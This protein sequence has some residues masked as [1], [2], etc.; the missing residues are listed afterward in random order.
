MNTVPYLDIQRINITPGLVTI[1]AACRYGV[2]ACLALFVIYSSIENE[3]TASRPFTAALL[4]LTYLILFPPLSHL[5]LIQEKFQKTHLV[6]FLHS[7]EL[8]LVFYLV[9]VQNWTLL[10]SFAVW[11]IFLASSAALFGWLI[12]LLH[13]SLTVVVY[14]CKEMM[15]WTPGGTPDQSMGLGALL[16]LLNVDTPQHW[17][18]LAIFCYV[19]IICRVAHQQAVALL[20]V[21]ALQQQ[22]KRMLLHYVP[23]DLAKSYKT[24][25]PG[26][27][28][29]QWMTIV[30]IDLADFSAATRNLPREQLHEL[31]NRF[32][33]VTNAQIEQ[34]GGYVSKFL[35]DGVLGVFPVDAAGA[36]KSQRKNT[37]QQAVNCIALLTENLTAGV[38]VEGAEPKLPARAGIA[39]G[40][41]AI[42]A[43]GGGGRWDH[44][45]IG[46]TV[47]LAAR[48]QA[49]AHQYGGV[50]ID[51]NTAALIDK[52]RLEG[53]EINLQLKGVGRQM[54]YA[55]T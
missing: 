28:D 48:L 54:A 41:C 44:T 22:D 20:R 49:H 40:Y 4:P 8:V 1:L 15:G 30:F 47:N 38:D 53:D 17:A 7:I 43:W 45:V 27:V 2:Y 18:L 21:Q 19:I 32:I 52:N 14:V 50:L 33:T 12:F 13:L 9:D 34:W 35:G 11:L 37:A 25:Y 16:D 6:A 51:S 3:F 39:S 46:D 42:G 26:R 31:V 10:T 55:I 5:L 36:L 29:H 23:S 24:Q